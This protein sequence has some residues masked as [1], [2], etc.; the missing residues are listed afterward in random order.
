MNYRVRCHC[1]CSRCDIC[2]TIIQRGFYF[3]VVVAVTSCWNWVHVVTLDS[4]SNLF[5]ALFFK[6]I[7]P[8]PLMESDLVSDSK[9]SLPIVSFLKAAGDH[10][11][12]LCSHTQEVKKKFDFVLLVWP[13]GV[14]LDTFIFHLFPQAP[15]SPAFQLGF[16]SSASLLLLSLGSFLSVP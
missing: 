14:M 16:F 13:V 11:T 3:F 4:I 10:L 5:T 7:S 12:K 9:G 6:Y 2:C 15:V 1:E 8:P